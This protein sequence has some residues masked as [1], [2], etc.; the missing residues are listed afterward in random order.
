MRR[1]A[2]VLFGALFVAA[3]GAGARG[4]TVDVWDVVAMSADL[5]WPYYVA[6]YDKRH[7]TTTGAAPGDHCS[8]FVATGAYTK[9]HRVVIAHNNWTGYL[10]GARWD[11]AF[12]VAPA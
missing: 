10:D 11:M 4:V 8:A 12:D 1:A 3:L 2:I 6:V 5:E 7:K 9:D